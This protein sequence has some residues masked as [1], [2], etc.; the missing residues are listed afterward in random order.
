M[1]GLRKTK[2]ASALA[3][4]RTE[5]FPNITLRVLLRDQFFR[6]SAYFQVYYI[7][8][9]ILHVTLRKLS[10]I[11]WNQPNIWWISPS[12]LL[13]VVYASY[14]T[15]SRAAVCADLTLE[16][17]FQWLRTSFHLTAVKKGVHLKL[18]ATNSNVTNLKTIRTGFLNLVF[19]W[20]YLGNFNNTYITSKCRITN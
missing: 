1:E 8:A 11:K 13:N 16:K 18:T 20:L 5:H 10:L 9:V 7:R 15:S 12:P 2:I 19:E 6:V 4:I 14:V 3:G 17:G